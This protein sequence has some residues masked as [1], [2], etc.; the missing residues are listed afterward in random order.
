MANWFNK[1]LALGQME[2]VTERPF[3]PMP[4]AQLSVFD[5]D[6]PRP[7]DFLNAKDLRAKMSAA[8]DRQIQALKP[9]DGKSLKEYHRVIGT[10][11]RVMVGGGL[12]DAA[13]VVGTPV[14]DSETRDGITLRR[15]LLNRKDL[16]EQVPAVGIKGEAFDG[17]VVVWVHP[18]GK[19]SLWKDGKLVPEAQQILDQKAAIL[20]FDAFGTGE[21]RPEK[22]PAVDSV[23][24]GFTFGYN[25]PL[26]AQ[27]VHDILTAVAFVHGHDLTKKVHLVGWQEAGP[28]VLL[29]RGLCADNVARTAADAC[30]LR[31]EAIRKMDDPM[32]LPGAVKYGELEA[33]AGLAAPGELAI[34]NPPTPSSGW[35]KAAYQSAG[36]GQQLTV[37]TEAKTANQVIEWLLR[38]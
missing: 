13:E 24:A 12:P 35:L 6:H 18:R 3:E 15:F 34:N 32:L 21:L 37:Q 7:G 4:P 14:G 9:T 1:H 17:T 20:A 29:A 30:G 22:M 10:A 27:R 11:L 19:Q 2:P 33:L 23:F 28:W 16:K 31:F 5:A 38:D 25:R 8:S 26:L 36:A